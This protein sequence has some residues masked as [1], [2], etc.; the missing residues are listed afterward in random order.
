MPGAHKIGAAIS[1]PR[2]AGGKITD[3]RIFSALF[4][5]G[6][7]PPEKL[8]SKIIGIPLQSQILSTP[9]LFHALIFGYGGDQEVA[10]ASLPSRP[11]NTNIVRGLS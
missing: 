7:T 11:R 10:Q 5:Q 6:F 1:G 3:T 8:T 4:L 9:N 2:I